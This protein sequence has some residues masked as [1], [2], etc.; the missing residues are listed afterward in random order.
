MRPN[1]PSVVQLLNKGLRASIDSSDITPLI[2]S[3]EVSLKYSAQNKKQFAST[4]ISFDSFCAPHL[5]TQVLFFDALKKCNNNVSFCNFPIGHFITSTPNPNLL[6]LA[7]DPL[8]LIELNRQM[9]INIRLDEAKVTD[10]DKITLINDETV[11]LS[12]LFREWLKSIEDESLF[13]IAINGFPFHELAHRD[14]CL[15]YKSTPDLVHTNPY[16]K[17]LYVQ[18]NKFNL[19]LLC[20]LLSCNDIGEFCY[21]MSLYTA[22]SIYHFF[23]LQTS[24]KFRVFNR[25]AISLEDFG[26]KSEM[27]VSLLSDGNATTQ[28]T[29]KLTYAQIDGIK[30]CDRAVNSLDNIMQKRMQGLGSHTYSEGI[31]AESG[32]QNE[33]AKWMAKQK[34][35]G[36]QVAT[37]FTS[38]PDELIGQQMNYKHF[39]I[40]LSHLGKP[41]FFNQEEWIEKTIKHF[42]SINKECSLIVRFH[43]RLAADKRGLP[44]SQYFSKIW[45]SVL[46]IVEHSET[47]RLVHPADKISSYWLGINSDLIL[48][49][50]STIGLEFA[51]CGKIVTNAFYNC[52]LGGGAIYPVLLKSPILK[53]TDQYFERV[54]RLLYSVKNNLDLDPYDFVSIDE[55]RKAFFVA[56]SAGLVN[57][58]NLPQ[59]QTQIASPAVL[60]QQMIS[61]LSEG[62]S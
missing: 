32:E 35:D 2:R 61:I 41:V 47:V 57:I 39:P 4:I 40:D 45:S 51:V 30:T 7:S 24:R 20:L 10:C 3:I 22:T 33:F 5:E 26:L 11:E 28:F 31:Q 13:N 15:T 21:G 9:S 18:S 46:D 59:L 56:F 1:S 54:D 37:L 23:C 48:N 50:W 38:S 12:K 29:E 44:E 52:P 49:G 6:N 19:W 60:T 16:F 43:P 62:K 34:K 27:Y 14:L 55:A 53:T 25:P 42:K 36:R 17:H 8:Q 58:H